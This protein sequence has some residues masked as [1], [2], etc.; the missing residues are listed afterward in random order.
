MKLIRRNNDTFRRRF[1]QQIQLFSLLVCTNKQ[2]VE[3]FHSI[4]SLKQRHS[5]H[6]KLIVSSSVSSSSLVV[7]AVLNRS[8]RFPYIVVDSND[9]DDSLPTDDDDDDGQ[10]FTLDNVNDDNNETIIYRDNYFMRLALEQAK[11][12]AADD[13]V[14]IG[15]IV[16]EQQQEQLYPPKKNKKCNDINMN[17]T[18]S[19]TC[20]YRILS[21]EYNRVEQLHDASGHAE[22]LALRSAAR[23][24]QNWR[25]SSSTTH[26]YNTAATS[27]GT[28]TTTTVLLY[29]TME[30][31]VMCLSA[32]LLF[33]IDTIIYCIPDHRLGAVT[34][35]VPLL[36]VS[37]K[38]PYHTI[39]TIQQITNA[40]IQQDCSTIIQ[41]FFR[42]K[43]RRR[44]DDNI[45]E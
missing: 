23:K 3:S 21:R 4:R 29:C 33:R 19:S 12:A 2:T 7:V 36:S 15:A 24:K 16:V 5:C 17:T 9:D 37:P 22:L 20:K 44:N 6:Q 38:H 43:R 41:D 1:L 31:C 18:T 11:L 14:P 28:T 34:S 25:L 10:Y 39:P 32:C 8:T 13:E 45:I 40:T 35:Y 42:A 27:K 26:N 30:P